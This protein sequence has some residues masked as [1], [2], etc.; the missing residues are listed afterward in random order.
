MT[1]LWPWLAVV[2]LGV[3]HGLSPASGW[4]LVAGRGLQDGNAARA[5]QALPPI[6]LGQA[7]SIAVAVLAVN[8]GLALDR[9]LAQRLAGAV[10]IGMALLRL[11]LPLPLWLRVRLWGW[12]RHAA[13]T[14]GPL[15]SVVR[16]AGLALWSGLMAT[17][18]GAGLMLVPALAPLCLTGG[19]AGP[20][21]ASGSLLLAAAALAAHLA[22]MLL[23]TG[24]L[25]CAICRGAVRFPALAASALPRHA[26]SAAL[27]VTGGWLLLAG[28]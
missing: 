22:A 17:A 1:E 19:T 26:C 15:R 8:G 2:G 10:L 28:H 6:V 25:A 9:V 12:L 23:T 5:W 4:T 24:A 7:G 13:S 21:T 14:C 11:R 18:H 27:A 16:P 3:L 20:V